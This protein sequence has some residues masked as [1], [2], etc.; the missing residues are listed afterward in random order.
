MISGIPVKFFD[1]EQWDLRP[2][3]TY[4]APIGI[5]SRFS[6]AKLRDV[7]RK[8]DA[9]PLHFGIGY[10]WRPHELNLLLAIKKQTKTTSAY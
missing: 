9:T 4:I 8:G 1:R 3:G 6:Q 10:R 2:F 5:F 7:F